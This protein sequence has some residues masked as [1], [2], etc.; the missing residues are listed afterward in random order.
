MVLMMVAMLSDIDGVGVFVV[1]VVGA[2]STIVLL[3]L[4]LPLLFW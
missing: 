4:Q 3:L 1:S 2:S